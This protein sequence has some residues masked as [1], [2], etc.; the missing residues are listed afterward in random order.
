MAKIEAHR[1]QN[2]I[3][4]TAVEF[5]TKLHAELKAI[6]TRSGRSHFHTRQ[7]I[8]N[9]NGEI[10]QWL[11]TATAEA[12][13]KP[14]HLLLASNPELT[15]ETVAAIPALVSETIIDMF[16]R[17]AANWSSADETSRGTITA[18]VATNIEWHVKTIRECAS[19]IADTSKMLPHPYR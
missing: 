16:E 13:L 2:N 6:K 4:L 11:L 5:F 17:Q 8:S 7:D 14:L 3:N 1:F 19:Q 18:V 9:V 12:A 10:H 15:T